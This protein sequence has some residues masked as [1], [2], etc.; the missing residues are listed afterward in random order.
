MYIYWFGPGK[1]IKSR[2][3]CFYIIIF[4]THSHTHKKVDDLK[5]KSH[6][7]LEAFFYGPLFLAIVANLNVL[8]SLNKMCTKSLQKRIFLK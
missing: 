7:I 2:T 8:L 3:C 6:Q 1:L 4:S 5:G